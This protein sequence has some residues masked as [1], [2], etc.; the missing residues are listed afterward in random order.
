MEVHPHMYADNFNPQA[1]TFYRPIDAALRWCGLVHYE[2]EIL[3]AAWHCPE[4]LGSLFPQWPCLHANTEKIYDAMR[5]GELPYGY[6]GVSVPMGSPLEPGQITVRHSDLRLWMQR[7]Y[8]DQRP[9]F[10]FESVND[11]REQISPAAYLFL[12]AERDALVQECNTLQRQLQ[13]VMADLQALGLEQ[14]SLNALVKSQ[15]QLSERS[16]HTYL[17]IIG[18][19]T[20]TVL[21]SSP[22]GKPLSVFENQTAIVDAV[23]ARFTDIPGLSKRTLDAKFAAANRVLKKTT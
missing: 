15:G 22:A 3:Q 18:A 10:L 5:N 19:L 8:P 7:Y 4:R 12:Q 9:G 14:K 17:Q 20:Y 2:A 6:L 1:K 23:T 13:D 11:T 16:E 21:D